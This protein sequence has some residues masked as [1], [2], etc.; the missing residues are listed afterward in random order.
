MSNKD[1]LDIDDS[2]GLMDSNMDGRISKKELADVY[3]NAG[4]TLTKEQID[5][6][7]EASYSQE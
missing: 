6:I 1:D 3:K 2:L 4:E 7:F 5:S